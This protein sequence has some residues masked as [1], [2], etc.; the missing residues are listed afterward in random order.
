MSPVGSGSQTAGSKSTVNTVQTSQSSQFEIDGM[1]EASH[2]CVSL[3]A[4]A[5]RTGQAG[6]S[7]SSLWALSLRRESA[8]NTKGDLD[9]PITHVDCLDEVLLFDL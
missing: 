7:E 2:R 1:R 6:I 9:Q 4:V 3:P 8:N 5:S